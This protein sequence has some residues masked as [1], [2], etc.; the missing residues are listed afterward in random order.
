M[1][2]ESPAWR[3]G[4]TVRTY[5]ALLLLVAVC[6]IRIEPA[7]KQFPSYEELWVS[8]DTLAR[9]ARYHGVLSMKITDDQA[10]IWRNARWIPV[11]KRNRS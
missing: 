5:I 9:L 3:K 1:K 11:L 10:F 8:K 4:G 6:S 7:P 2:M